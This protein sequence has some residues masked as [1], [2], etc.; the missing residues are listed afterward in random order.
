MP[1]LSVN[2]LLCQPASAAHASYVTV[3]GMARAFFSELAQKGNALYNVLPD[4]VSR[5]SDPVVG[6]KEEDFHTV[7][8]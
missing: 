7:M 3:A 1:L 4:I 5:L 6:L 8:Q 2:T